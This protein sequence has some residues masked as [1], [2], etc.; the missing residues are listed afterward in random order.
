MPSVGRGPHSLET[1][2]LL[3]ALLVSHPGRVHL[4]RG[5]PETAAVNATMGLRAE[6]EARLG[7]EEEGEALWE[8]LNRV[9]DWLPLAALVGGR[10]L[11]VH[12]GI[13]GTLRSVADIDALR[14]P[15][16]GGG[17]I[18]DVAN[19]L[20]WSDPATAPSLQGIAPSSMRGEGATEFGA[21]RLRDFCAAAGVEMV[22][23]G[24][25]CVAHG[26]ERFG[27]AGAGA[28]QLLTVFSAAN[29]CGSLANSA[30]L[31]LLDRDLVCTALLLA[32]GE[33]EG[34]GATRGDA[35]GAAEEEEE[36]EGAAAWELVAAGGRAR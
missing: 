32:S 30:A 21:G 28:P 12:G 4:L 18:G 10:V 19:D 16:D 11:C 26:V 33:A 25:E 31:L 29:Y 13:G 34:A 14:R 3:L 22:V 6:C 36:E 24:H 23:R 20:L 27:G 7:S 17:P 35:R 5:N 15:L 8:R 1:V 9:F 2:A